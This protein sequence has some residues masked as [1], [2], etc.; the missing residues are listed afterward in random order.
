MFFE[1]WANFIFVFNYIR[2]FIEAQNLFLWWKLWYLMLLF[3]YAKFS[4]LEISIIWMIVFDILTSQKKVNSYGAFAKSTLMSHGF[5]FSTFLPLVPL[6]QRE[7]RIPV[8]SLITSVPLL[9]SRIHLLSMNFPCTTWHPLLHIK[10]SF[11]NWVSSLYFQLSI[12]NAKMKSSTDNSIR[13]CTFL[14]CVFK[15]DFG[16]ESDFYYLSYYVIGDEIGMVCNELMCMIL[17]QYVPPY[18]IWDKMLLLQ[19][20]CD[21]Y[22]VRCEVFLHIIKSS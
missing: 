5:F 8:T 9:K 7:L 21:M 12:R 17:S 16:M 20:K 3:E 2:I 19:N 15:I 18:C 6:L 1:A 22:Y 13:I 4:N 14:H 10:L 11:Q